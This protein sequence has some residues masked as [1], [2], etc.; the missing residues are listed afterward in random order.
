MR[1]HHLCGK[2]NELMVDLLRCVPPG[3][4]VLDP[5]AGSGGRLREAA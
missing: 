4:T 1:A 5:F 3:G 2:P